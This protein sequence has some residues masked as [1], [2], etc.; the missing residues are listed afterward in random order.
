M[1]VSHGDGRT[2]SRVRQCD[3][4]AARSC[5][6]WLASQRCPARALLGSLR[7]VVVSP[8][9]A[10]GE[11]LN[12]TQNSQSSTW[13]ITLTRRPFAASAVLLKEGLRIT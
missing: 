3:Q 11:R 13:P 8:S 7:R 12:S 10:S 2:G 5:F 6:M 4:P 9:L 1:I